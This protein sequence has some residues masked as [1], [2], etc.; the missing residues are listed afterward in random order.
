MIF[1]LLRNGSAVDTFEQYGGANTV[2]HN[3]FSLCLT[4]YGKALAAGETFT[5]T[6]QTST[7]HNNTGS[8]AG[9][10]TQASPTW[11]QSKVNVLR[12]N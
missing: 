4:L 2:D 1:Q 9:Q 8:N 10:D 3:V 12:I 5:I 7:Q 11:T 6:V